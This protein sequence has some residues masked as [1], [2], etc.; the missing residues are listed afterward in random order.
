[1]ALNFSPSRATRNLLGEAVS[2]YS[3]KMD[4][5]RRKSVLQAMLLKRA[6]DTSNHST[7]TGREFRETDLQ[8]IQK[9]RQY[10]S[11]MR[12]YPPH[13]RKTKNRS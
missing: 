9:T 2:D 4:K 6:C 10:I 8:A 5:V 1:V 7:P 13:T 12:D 3:M 11:A